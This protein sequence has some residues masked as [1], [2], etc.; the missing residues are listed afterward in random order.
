MP[1][2]GTVFVVPLFMTLAGLVTGLDFAGLVFGIFSKCGKNWTVW[3][4][5]L[6][7]VFNCGSFCISF[8]HEILLLTKL[9]V[10]GMLDGAWP[11]RGTHSTHDGGR[12]C[13]CVRC[14]W[15]NA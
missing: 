3:I 4:V 14:V 6:M 10:S 13:V 11:N 15:T 12:M 1:L 7:V 9:L 2:F 8:M 5:Y